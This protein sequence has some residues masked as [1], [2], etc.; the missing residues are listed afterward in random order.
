MYLDGPADLWIGVNM[1]VMF[2][3]EDLTYR[4]DRS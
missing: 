1:G 3:L 4:S 2:V